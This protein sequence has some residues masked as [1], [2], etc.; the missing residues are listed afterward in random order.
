MCDFKGKGVPKVDKLNIKI[1]CFLF[2]LYL[3]WK[4]KKGF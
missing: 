4:T 1:M 3:K 2:H